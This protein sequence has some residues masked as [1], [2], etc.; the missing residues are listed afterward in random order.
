MPFTSQQMVMGFRYYHCNLFI[1][2]LNRVYV[3]D[4]LHLKMTYV[5]K[6]NFPYL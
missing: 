2:Q 3:L 1:F 5:D 6:N 4:R